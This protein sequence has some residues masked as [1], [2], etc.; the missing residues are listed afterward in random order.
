MFLSSTHNQS[1]ENLFEKN[2]HKIEEQ[3]KYLDES[4]RIAKLQ[5]ADVIKV[6]DDT[7]I[8]QEPIQAIGDVTSLSEKSSKSRSTKQ[9]VV[10]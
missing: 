10:N 5:L 1:L 2:L 3:L 6:Q 4:Q 7:F 9:I 8:Y